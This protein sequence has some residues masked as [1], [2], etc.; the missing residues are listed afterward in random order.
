M[1]IGIDCHNLEKNRTGVG[2][3]LKCLLEQ[4]SQFNLAP[5]L[6]FILYFK[7]EIPADLVLPTSHFE[8]KILPAPMGIQSNMLFLH[9][10]LPGAAK[11]DKIDILFCPGY[12][13][14]LFY[15]GRL[16][17]ALHDIIYEARPDL[18]YWP[19]LLDRFLLRF[20]SRQSAK[21]AEKIF[22]CSKFTKSE[23]IKYYQ[24]DPKKVFHIPLASVIASPALFNKSAG[25]SNPVAVTIRQ[26]YHIQ[27]K[28]IFYL[29]S[30]FTRRCLPEA[31]SAFVQITN[32]LTNYQFLIIGHNYTRPFVDIKKMIRIANQKIGREAIIHFNYIDEQDLASLY[33]S[34]DL[35]IWLSE[36]E[37]FG[38]PILEA[39][40]CRAPV[41][42]TPT[43][44]IPEVAG[45]AVIYVNNPKDINEISLAIHR[46]LTD[47]NLRQ[48]LIKKGLIQSQ[49]FSWQE[50]AKET[51]K[52]IILKT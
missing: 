40:S 39:I 41:I 30:I 2:R 19:S 5:D 14:P 7:K 35:F 15:R 24:I 33:Q 13:A 4:W 17:L 32:Q 6:K 11:K 47:D 1:H 42:T 20:V 25:R 8:K 27:N 21:K 52:F 16:A 50:T 31:I 23:V 18:Y 9:W 10:L 28:F 46:G 12:V 36:Y 48:D 34:T 29:G 26:K 22:A 45:E 3:Y 37:G 49:K 51:L 43:S 44:S 38:L